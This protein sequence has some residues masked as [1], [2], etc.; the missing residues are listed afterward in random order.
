MSPEK[1]INRITG[2]A[3]NLLRNIKVVFTYIDEDMLKKTDSDL[4][5][6]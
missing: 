1:H 4:N 2:N 3:Y 6:T 5:T